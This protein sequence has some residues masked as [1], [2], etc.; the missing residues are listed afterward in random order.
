MGK[1]VRVYMFT[2]WIFRKFVQEL[3][4][5]ITTDQLRLTKLRPVT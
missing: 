2:H 3:L 4:L 1:P 5:S